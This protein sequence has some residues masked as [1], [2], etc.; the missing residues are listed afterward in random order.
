MTTN[1]ASYQVF[2]GEIP[3]GILV[4]HT[5]DNR[6]C[7]NPEHLFLG[8]PNDNSIDMV[9]KGRDKFDI[10]RKLTNE[11]ILKIRELYFKDI[12]QQEIARLFNV[13]QATVSRIGTGVSYGWIN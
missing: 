5:C 6:R 11:Q 2:C 10:N 4:C 8:T 9:S 3:N 1:R 13:S 12:S 7:I